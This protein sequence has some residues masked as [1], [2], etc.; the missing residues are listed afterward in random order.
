MKPGWHRWC[1]QTATLP[2]CKHLKECRAKGVCV[3]PELCHERQGEYMLY[4][5]YEREEEPMPDWGD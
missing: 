2:P 1:E 4:L 3:N 5:R